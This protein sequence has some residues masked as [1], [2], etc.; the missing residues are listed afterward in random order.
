MKG[1]GEEQGLKLSATGVA[2]G[3]PDA[4]TIRYTVSFKA[5]TSESTFRE[6]NKVADSIRESVLKKAQMERILNHSK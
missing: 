3:I 1:Q 2:S 6:A 5:Q 4:A